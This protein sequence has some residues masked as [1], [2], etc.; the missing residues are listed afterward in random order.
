MLWQGGSEQLSWFMIWILLWVAIS[1]ALFGVY[2]WSAGISLR[3]SRAW[4]AYAQKTGMTFVQKGPLQPPALVG[5]LRGHDV[6]MYMMIENDD[7]LRRKV[8]WTFIEVDLNVSADSQFIIAKGQYRDMFDGMEGESINLDGI[9][10]NIAKA[11]NPK[12]YKKYMTPGRI[13]VLKEFWSWE[14]YQ[15]IILCNPTATTLIAQTGL[16]LHHP[17]DVHHAVKTMLDWAERLDAQG[18]IA[19]EDDKPKKKSSGKKPTKK[20]AASKK[21]PPKAE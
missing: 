13:A 5:Q 3:Q 4:K 8:I 17:R 10:A 18:A 21:S 12:S 16:P 19:A 11:Q 20:K 9:I 14:D 2:L 6:R 1:L 15:P 7:I